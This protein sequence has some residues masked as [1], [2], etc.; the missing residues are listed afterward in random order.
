MCCLYKRLKSQKDDAPIIIKISSKANSRPVHVQKDQNHND[1]PINDQD[2]IITN[3]TQRGA[4]D[5]EKELPDGSSDT[6]SDTGMTGI[7][8]RTEQIGAD[9]PKERDEV[10]LEIE[11]RNQSDDD[12][13]DE[14]MSMYN[15]RKK[16]DGTNIGSITA[17]SIAASNVTISQM[18]LNDNG[19]LPND[20]LQFQ[21]SSQ[22]LL[23]AA[24]DNMEV[25]PQNDLVM[26]NQPSV[27]Q[28]EEGGDEEEYYD[29]DQDDNMSM[30]TYKKDG[31]D[32][33]T[34]I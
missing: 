32:N 8:L 24:S 6:D 5:D 25:A 17:A 15:H 3:V 22:N 4:E 34:G 7:T 16:D 30:Y 27:E 29:D 12:D 1:G 9:L 18:N 2:V 26:V 10:D 14:N 20:Q 21:R 19:S 23:D 28:P 11:N 33:A 13:E 31:K